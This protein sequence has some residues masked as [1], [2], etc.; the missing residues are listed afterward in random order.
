MSHEPNAPEL[1]AG[2]ATAAPEV[3][4]GAGEPVPD[5]VA[6]AARILSGD[7]RPEDYLPVPDEVRAAA[8]DAVRQIETENGF[9]LTA[10]A[11]QHTLNNWTLWHYHPDDVVLVRH[12]ERG[13]L[14]LA[15]GDDQMHQLRLRL[16]FTNDYRS[17]FVLSFPPPV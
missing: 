1:P 7:V 17:G 4:T 11:K 14:V 3:P 5:F 6:R 2:A 8:A 9:E 12:T 13:V 15:A 10:E 16:G